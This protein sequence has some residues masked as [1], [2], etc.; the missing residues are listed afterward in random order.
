[1]TGDNVPTW[2]KYAAALIVVVILG[3]VSGMPDLLLPS[4]Q[5]PAWTPLIGLAHSLVAGASFSL[6]IVAGTV[7]FSRSKKDL[8]ARNL[9]RGV[10]IFLLFA[11]GDFAVEISVRPFFS[12]TSGHPDVQYALARAVQAWKGLLAPIVLLL[13]FLAVVFFKHY[14]RR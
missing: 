6:I 13:V 8:W 1:M 9:R 7:L 3:V 10:L 2:I 12:Q 11:I 5:E 4:P 14:R